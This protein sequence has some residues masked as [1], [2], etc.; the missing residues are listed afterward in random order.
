MLEDLLHEERS[1]KFVF[2]LDLLLGWIFQFGLL[3]N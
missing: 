2:V 3:K 1:S